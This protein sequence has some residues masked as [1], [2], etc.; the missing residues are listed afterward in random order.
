MR[1]TADTLKKNVQKRYEN[2]TVKIHQ[3]RKNDNTRNKF[4][5]QKILVRPN[6]NCEEWQESINEEKLVL[7]CR[8]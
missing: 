7:K 1:Q 3:I 6:T 8:L 2:Q 5:S 4:A